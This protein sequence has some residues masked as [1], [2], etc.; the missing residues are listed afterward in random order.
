MRECARNMFAIVI[1]SCPHWGWSLFK[2]LCCQV[3]PC[4]ELFSLCK[5]LVAKEP[6]HNTCFVCERWHPRKR[7]I[8]YECS[9]PN[10]FSPQSCYRPLVEWCT[11][12]SMGFQNVFLKALAFQRQ[13]QQ[14][15]LLSSP[16][17]RPLA[18]RIP[19]NMI[20]FKKISQK[21]FPSVSVQLTFLEG[22]CLK[23]VL[24]TEM[25]QTTC[26]RKGLHKKETTYIQPKVIDIYLNDPPS[27]SSKAYVFSNHLLCIWPPHRAPCPLS[28]GALLPVLSVE[29][30]PKPLG[31]RV[32]HFRQWQMQV[33]LSLL[34]GSKWP[35]PARSL[36]TSSC[37]LEL[38]S[39]AA[40]SGASFLV[41]ARSGFRKDP[42]RSC[43]CVPS[44]LT[45][46]HVKTL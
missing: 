45:R 43:S 14:I 39:T 19:P 44:Q 12:S 40:A 23:I 18:A 27:F 46:H 38:E 33:W 3:P 41:W 17:Y 34:L 20:L 29:T 21:H 11:N 37:T 35:W 36:A 32:M 31:F 24:S 13:L 15:F 7:H 25:F 1:L 26:W 16:S 2:G 10:C 42:G 5:P 30:R 9:W 4:Q 8:I 22:C 6:P 28:E